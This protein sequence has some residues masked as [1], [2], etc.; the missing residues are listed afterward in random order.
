MAEAAYAVQAIALVSTISP[1]HRVIVQ[2]QCRCDFGA[3]PA[4]IEKN[5]RVRSPRDAMF[6]KPVTR[7]PYQ[8]LPLC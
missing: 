5:N 2:Q 6:G 1:A 4:G 8:R 3:T 7:Q